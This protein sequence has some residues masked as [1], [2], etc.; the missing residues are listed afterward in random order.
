MRDA[1]HET[2]ISAEDTSV[3][4]FILENE[5]VD[6][7]YH[8]WVY[9]FERLMQLEKIDILLHFRKVELEK[10]FTVVG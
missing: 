3:L 5:I 6:L 10:H 4:Y 2:K 9:I 8:P 7:Y 1:C